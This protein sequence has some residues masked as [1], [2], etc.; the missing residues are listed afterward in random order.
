MWTGPSPL[1][2][3][4]CRLEPDVREADDVACQGIQYAFDGPDLECDIPHSP[5]CFR[6]Y[7]RARSTFKPSSPR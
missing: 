1:Y 7:G 4:A 2:S 6:I 5:F 3:G